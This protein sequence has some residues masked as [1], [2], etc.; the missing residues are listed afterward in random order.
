M[1]A[2]PTLNNRPA[3]NVHNQQAQIRLFCFPYAGGSSLAYRKW[4]GQLPPSV[5]VRPVQLPGRGERLREPPF[6]HW[7]S[8]VQSL[9]PEISPHLDRPFV[10]FG[11]SMGATIAFELAR[12]LR[13]TRGLEPLHLFASGRRAPHEPITERP[14]HNLPDSELKDELR[15]L[16]GTPQEVLD[17]PELMNLM[18]PLLRA[19]FSVSE[20][21]AYEPGPPLRC[22]ITAF[23]GLR[24]THV[25]R[26]MLEG[27]REHTTG[28]FTLRMLPGDHFFINAEQH[29][30]LRVLTQELQTRYGL[31]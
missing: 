16:N 11:H 2:V 28:H 3:T 10:L 26:E 19:D 18:L 1:N 29:S 5:E 15:R 27:W 21:Y 31:F 4:P 9:V 23:G 7:K 8:L 22:P 14:L 12:V 20:N 13:D 17:D 30:L 24:D 6:T 25:T